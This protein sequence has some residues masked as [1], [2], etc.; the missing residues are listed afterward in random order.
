MKKSRMV[1]TFDPYGT[2]MINHGIVFWLCSIYTA[3]VRKICLRYLC[4]EPCSFCHVNILIQHSSFLCFLSLYIRYDWIDIMGYSKHELSTINMFS[5]PPKNCYI[6]PLPSHSGN[7]STTGA[8]FCP[9]SG[10][11]EEVRLYLFR[12]R[13]SEKLCTRQ[14]RKVSWDMIN[15]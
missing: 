3:A 8:F 11:C 15:T 14:S 13:L 6:T 12:E 4:C 7:L 1:M 5:T 9:Q 10:L 2:L